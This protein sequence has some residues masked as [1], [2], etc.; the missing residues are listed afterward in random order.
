VPSFAD[1]VAGSLISPENPRTPG[2][3]LPIDSLAT[4]GKKT[5][6]DEGAVAMTQSIQTIQ[7]RV[8]R[9]DNETAAR[10]RQLAN[11]GEELA[12][13]ARSGYT[14]AHT[15]AIETA[16]AVTFVDTLTRPID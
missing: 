2:T 16:E 7:T 6:E 5:V 11:R 12:S 4:K 10:S 9:D 1:A 3:S 15:A 8:T 14:L 13:Y